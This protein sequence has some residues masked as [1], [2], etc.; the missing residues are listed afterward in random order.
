MSDHDSHLALFITVNPVYR[1][2]NICLRF[3]LSNVAIFRRWESDPQFLRNSGGHV[4]KQ[5]AIT[6]SYFF[7]LAV[8]SLSRRRSLSQQK[9]P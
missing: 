7:V 2:Q 1:C 3:V 8:T 4:R 5:P 6:V 9:Q